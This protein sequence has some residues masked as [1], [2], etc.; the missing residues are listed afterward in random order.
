MPISV[1]S[2][3]NDEPVTVFQ[4]M[5]EDEIQNLA[6]Q[7][8]HASGAS[9][10]VANN[11][12]E[13]EEF[14][15]VLTRESTRV[16]QLLVDGV[17]PFQADDERLNPDSKNFQAKYWIKN[18]RQLQDKDVDYYKPSQMGVV[19]KD[20]QCYGASR[21]ADFKEDVINFPQKWFRAL[22]DTV[23]INALDRTDILKSMDALILPGSMTVVLGR[24]GA[25]CTTL[26]KTISS[27]TYGFHVSKNSR[28]S[29]D[30]LSP[31]EMARHYRGDIIYNAE[32]ENHFPHLKVGQ[33]LNLASL[34]KVPQNRPPGISREE[35]ADHFT[36]VYMAMYGLSHTY[37]TKVGNEYVRGVS[38]G[39]RK[40]V[41]IAEVSLCGGKVQCWDNSTRGLDSAS[42]ENFVRCLKL[43]SRVLKT[44]SIVS[45]YQ[46][47]QKTYDMFDKVL[48]LYEGRL[49]YYGDTQKAKQYFEVMGFECPARQTVADFL[50]SITSPAERRAKKGWER[51]VPNTS[52]EFEIYWK[53]STQYAQLKQEIDEYLEITDTNKQE[54][55]NH[56]H[57]SKTAKQA[58]HSN[59]SES[60]TVSYPMQI[61]YLTKRAFQR[62]LQDLSLPLFTI[63]SNF[64]MALI[65]GS[66]FY[67]LKNTT[68]DIYSRGAC[69]FFACLFNSM[70]SLLEVFALY[71]SRPIVEKHSQY[72]LYH[73]SAEAFASI[74]SEIPTK[75][76]SCVSF[77]LTLYFLVN[78][79]RNA[80]NFF[81]YFLIAVTSLFTMSHIF[82]TIGACTKSLSQAMTPASLIL[83]AMS[84][85]AGFVV[86][87]DYMLG[88]SRWIN[89]I[90]P[91]AY[92]FESMMINE[93]HGRHMKC[94]SIVPQGGKYNEIPLTNRICDQ[95][96]AIAGQ[97]WVD[98]EH[99]LRE[100]YTYSHGHKWRNWGIVI[101]FMFFFLF[102]YVMA[103][104]FNPSARQHG[105]KIVFLKKH[106]R[107]LQKQKKLGNKT[108]DPES[109]LDSVDQK[110][111]S[112]LTDSEDTENKNE[113][114]NL[115]SGDDIF[116]WKNVTY[117]VPYK[118]GTR[119]LLNGVDGWVKPG[120]LTALMGSSGAGKTTLLDVLADRATMGVVTGNMLVDGRPRDTSFQRSTGYV[121]QQ[122]LH[123]PTSTVREA[124]RFSAYLRQGCNVPKT[125]KDAYVEEVIHILEMNN[126][127]DVV[128]GVPGEGLNVE[129][130]KR[131]TIGVELVAKPKLLLFLDEPTSG[132]DSQTAWSI[133]CLI[134]KLSNA[135]QAIMC[136]IH[137]PSALLFAE[138]D[139]LLLLKSGGEVVYFGEIGEDA[140]TLINYFEGNG[141]IKCLPQANP[142]EWMLDAIGSTPG[143]QSDQDYHEIWINSPEHA[144]VI[145]ELERLETELI[146]KPELQVDNKESS[147]ASSLTTQYYEVTK[148]VF[149]QYW[150]SPEYIWS[151]IVL[152]MLSKLFNG[153]TFFR[154][155]NTI[156]GMQNQMFA[157]FMFTAAFATLVQQML[158]HF[159][160]QRDL[161]EARERPSKSFSWF[162]FIT[163][164]ITVEIPW[165]VITAT[166]AFF[167]FYYPVGFQHNSAI[168]G[169]TH[170]RGVLFWLFCIEFFLFSSTMGQAAIAGMEQQ[171]N[172]ANLSVFLYSFCMAFCGVLVTKDKLPGFW[173]FMYRVSPFTYWIAGV[174]NT[175]MGN[176]AVKCAK[177]ELL[178]FAPYGNLTCAE[179]M[180]PYMQVAGGYLVDPNATDMCQFCKINNTNVFLNSIDALNLS[181]WQNFGIFWVYIVVNIAATILLYWLVRVPKKGSNVKHV[182]SSWLKRYKESKSNQHDSTKRDVTGAEK[183]E[184]PSDDVSN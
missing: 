27:Q 29:Y 104:E 159:V 48:L 28:L 136:T 58:N 168:T 50:T 164:Q 132:L 66:I 70:M 94:T 96:G 17:P 82:R 83:I 99:Y 47:S 89:Y 119:R 181:R 74:V 79:R 121:Q 34:M 52:E 36:K 180:G 84:V 151:K 5:D 64:I 53:N 169:D 1:H 11:Q 49:I 162:A 61:R 73:P 116:H 98:G 146:K 2:D 75:V 25:G 156:Q 150:R 80:G 125:E 143:S 130:R 101:G 124:L 184:T 21:D 167:C 44:T 133:L 65:N 134:K 178:P 161:Y 144:A 32:V 3:L 39:E 20:L 107:E 22:S 142:A 117:D 59:P 171:Q 86:P 135:G 35:Y 93:F 43:S 54:F 57:A 147:Y 102:T 172:A 10:P 111:F 109:Q 68:G 71:E 100:A 115:D 139:N 127:A 108:N 148:R 31:Q 78:F 152:V 23:K 41:S 166:I 155:N 183:L 91:I 158:P 12:E 42:A 113:K 179:Y 18:L 9:I 38:G 95:V 177:N 76:I 175:A 51:K 112:M 87:V 138:F 85:Y 72:G 174:L 19:F 8:T 157:V 13:N 137:Q 170:T 140:K 16:S 63:L 26:L 110:A 106:L 40:R 56:L 154:A 120:T 97:D 92:V 131:L 126:Y 77:N 4:S 45:I 129:Q 141:S 160:A 6:R 145:A 62:I 33:T 149:Q 15:T 182:V 105:E 118:G 24:P 30:G 128:V 60:Y 7:L 173:I 163:A 46:C 55:M 176:T 114:I 67:N 90:N 123:L 153:F 37:F 14:R 165:M 103:V 81:F 69:L 122:D 88:W